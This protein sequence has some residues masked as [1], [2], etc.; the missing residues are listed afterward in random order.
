MEE[1]PSYLPIALLV[2]CLFLSAFFS[3][4]EAAFLYLDRV[5]LRHLVSTNAKGAKE[6]QGYSEKPGRLLSTVLLGNNAFNTAAASLGTALSLQLIENREVGIIAAT[7]AVTVLLLI[8]GEIIPKTIATTYSLKLA[9]LYWRPLR[10]FEIALR[11]LIWLI[12][13][14]ATGVQRII[15]NPTESSTVSEEDIRLIISLGRQEGAVEH[16]EAEMLEKVLEFGDRQVHEVMTPRTEI[17]WVQKGTNLRQFLEVY[18]EHSHTR[19]PVY[20]TKM[21]NVIG[22]L[23]IKD[24]MK[25]M[26]NKELGYDD[27]VSGVFRQAYF[28]PETKLVPHLVTELQQ[29]G[30]QMAILI[31][32]YGGTAGLVTLKRLV[33]EIVGRGGEEGTP[34]TSEVTPI[35]DYT[36]AVDASIRLEEA[37]EELSL[38]LPEGDYETLAGFLLHLIGRIPYKGEQISYNEFTFTVSEVSNVKIESVTVAVAPVLP[39]D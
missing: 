13:I 34:L 33:E 36:F 12:Q 39:E 35:D 25:A 6:I 18:S 19:F 32:E 17:V 28:V 29:A 23:S 10:A 37:N 27:E 38:S 20:E 22:L 24:V 8:F 21:D 14:F 26:A 16:S 7:I 15:G 31:D 9:M 5:R 1:L 2:M 30:H 11:P 3:S 4:S